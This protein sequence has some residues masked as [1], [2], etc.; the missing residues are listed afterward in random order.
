[1]S[2][3]VDTIPFSQV[4]FQNCFASDPSLSPELVQ[5]TKD[6]M[7][8]NSINSA[9]CAGDT[10]PLLAEMPTEKPDLRPNTLKKDA[11]K[12]AAD[13]KKKEAEEAR[14]K[15]LAEGK[16]VMEE[17]RIRKEEEAKRKREE[18]A[19]RIANRDRNR[20]RADD[21]PKESHNAFEVEE[22]EPGDEA[23]KEEE[24]TTAQEEEQVKKKWQPKKKGGKKK[25]KNF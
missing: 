3:P 8:I 18:E 6:D 19:A 12:L 24:A 23:V 20:R 15:M 13:L 11:K 1:M 16:K 2:Y 17:K 10:Y 25:K 14:V 7:C 9:V 4:Y 5:T 22:E 21:K